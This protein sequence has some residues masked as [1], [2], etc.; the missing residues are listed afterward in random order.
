ML[1]M[2]VTIHEVLGDLRASALDQRDKGDKFERLVQSFLR[3]DPE[4]TAKFEDV[5]TWTDWPLRGTRSDT[6]IDLV[7]KVR[8]SDTGELILSRYAR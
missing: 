7:A 1:P 4:W 8:E 5:W 6:G 3:T 2:S